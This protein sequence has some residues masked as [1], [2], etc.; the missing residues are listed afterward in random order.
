MKLYLGYY[1]KEVNDENDN[2]P[3]GIILTEEKDEIMVEYA[4]LIDTSKLLYDL[5]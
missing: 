4:M 5:M 1:E 2:Q 3:I